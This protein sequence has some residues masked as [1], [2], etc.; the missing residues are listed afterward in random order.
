V[1]GRPRGRCEVLVQRFLDSGIL[2]TPERC[3]TSAPAAVLCLERFCGTSDW[4]LFGLDLDDRKERRSSDTTVRAASYYAAERLSQQF[5]LVTL[6]HS[7]SILPIRFRCCEDCGKESPRAPT[8]RSSH[9]VT[10]RVRPGGRRPLCHF[11]RVHW[12]ISSPCWPGVE[13]VRTDWINKEI[14]LLAVPDPKLPEP[15]QDDLVRRSPRSKAT[16]H[17]CEHAR[18][19]RESARSGRLHLRDFVAA[20]WLASGLAI[21]SSSSS[22]KIRERRPFAPCRPI[23]SLRR[24][25]RGV[26][27]LAFVREV[28]SAISRRLA[29]LL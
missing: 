28:S 12:H 27:Y 2:R 13:T 25:S 17:G 11:T 24:F 26:V 6:I 5:D 23:L 29:D 1:S 10:R 4:K 16:S 9:N 21:S 18:H 20:T 7:L 15:V 8:F 19:A 3:S 14:S 22:M